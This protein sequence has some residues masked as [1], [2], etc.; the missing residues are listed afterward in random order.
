MQERTHSTSPA[1]P[2]RTALAATVRTALGF[3]HQ[4]GPLQR[5]GETERK[6]RVWSIHELNAAYLRVGG[7]VTAA[8]LD[9]PPGRTW[10]K[11]AVTAYIP[12]VGACQAFASWE[13]TAEPLGFG[14]DVVRLAAGPEIA[15]V[16][17]AELHR[18]AAADYTAA[19]DTRARAERT[20]ARST[21]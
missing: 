7:L 15:A 3:P 18:Q 4:A 20:W 9:A 19:A 5:L 6:V 14:L 11:V 13:P 16:R 21:V 12:G 1:A 8:A 17:V 10:L 2:Q